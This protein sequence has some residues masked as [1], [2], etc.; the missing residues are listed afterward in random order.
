MQHG[1]RKIKIKEKDKDKDKEKQKQ[2]KNSYTKE[3]YRTDIGEHKQQRGETSSQTV[4]KALRQV[5]T[6]STQDPKST[7]TRSQRKTWA[8]Q[9]KEY[10][11][12]MT[13]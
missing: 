5:K 8:T 9:E 11:L 6:Q 2:T 10:Y 4:V 3:E 13:Q 7:Q 1:E 12:W